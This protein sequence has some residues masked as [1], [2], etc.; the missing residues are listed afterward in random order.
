MDCSYEFATKTPCESGMFA[1]T[2]KQL[3]VVLYFRSSEML[4][5][6]PGASTAG[7]DAE[8]ASRDRVCTCYLLP[9]DQDILQLHW[10]RIHSA[11][12]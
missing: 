3:N 9:S 2:V 8:V 10:K 12:C 4:W 6:L 1:F 11:V 5:E 7:G